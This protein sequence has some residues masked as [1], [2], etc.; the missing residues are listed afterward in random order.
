[1]VL[2]KAFAFDFWERKSL[3]LDKKALPQFVQ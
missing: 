2:K 3:N 1:M